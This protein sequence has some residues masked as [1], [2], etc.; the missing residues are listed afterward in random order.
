M[1]A[2]QLVLSK[3]ML[4]A[5]SAVLFAT[6]THSASDGSSTEFPIRELYQITPKR[7]LLKHEHNVAD[8][9]ISVDED[10]N[11]RITL[12]QM[13]FT[14]AV[15]FWKKHMQLPRETF[16]MDGVCPVCN[17]TGPQ[18][19]YYAKSDQNKKYMCSKCQTERVKVTITEADRP[20]ASGC[21]SSSCSKEKEIRTFEFVFADRSKAK[22][23]CYQLNKRILG[24]KG[25][26]QCSQFGAGQPLR[27]YELNQLRQRNEDSFHLHNANMICYRNRCD[28]CHAPKGPKDRPS[29]WPGKICTKCLCEPCEGTGRRD[30]KKGTEKPCLEEHKRCI[31]C[32]GT[33]SGFTEWIGSMPNKRQTLNVLKRR[34]LNQSNTL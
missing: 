25:A 2:T 24:P 13:S 26:K 14:G 10:N 23:F 34:L 32:K 19:E 28:N 15:S 30:K 27:I 17:W 6:G 31:H 1:T 33:G 29:G 22:D 21:F 7:K 18:I 3:L 5:I 11:T 20:P 4:L 16:A 8:V 9:V 12:P